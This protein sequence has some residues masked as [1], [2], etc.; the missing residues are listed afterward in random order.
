MGIRPN[1][2]AAELALRLL[3]AAQLVARCAIAILVER[4]KTTLC[5]VKLRLF[6]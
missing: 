5:Q 2:E 3:I 1:R 6:A 4:A